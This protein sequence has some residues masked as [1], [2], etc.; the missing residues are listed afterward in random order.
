MRCINHTLG[1]PVLDQ[2]GLT[3]GLALPTA[4]TV[5]CPAPALTDTFPWSAWPR[6]R[7]AWAVAPERI[8]PRGRSTWAVAA[9]RMMPR[10]RSAWA[11]DSSWTY[12]AMA[13]AHEL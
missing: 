7:S 9:G 6:G 5:V 1:Y 10:G 8:M 13:G 2:R 12:D 3:Q 11:V 4:S